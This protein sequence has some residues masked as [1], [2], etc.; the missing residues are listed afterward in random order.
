MKPFLP[1]LLPISSSEDAFENFEPLATDATIAVATLSGMMKTSTKADLFWLNWLMREAQISNVLEGT[2]TTLDEVLGENAG[3]RVPRERKDD[4]IEVLNYRDAM[5]FGMEYIK[6]RKL[7]TLSFIKQLHSLLLRGARGENK[8]PGNF[9]TIQVHIGNPVIYTPPEAIHLSGLLDN[10]IAFI[11]RKDINPLVQTAI[12]HAQFEMIHPFCD[13]NGRIGRLLI[14]IFLAYRKVLEYPCFYMSAYLHKNRTAYYSSLN[15]ISSKNNWETWIKFFLKSVI[16]RCNENINLLN[17]MTKLY[18]KSKINFLDITGSA[19]AIEVLDYV[20]KKPAFTL[21]D[22]VKN[23]GV[24]IKTPAITMLLNKLE[25]AGVIAKV[26]EKI[27]RKPALWRFTELMN[28][29]ER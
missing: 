16:T 21:P 8:T 28:L 5:I 1:R 4:V 17:D 27:G 2:V 7:L 13:G 14:S 9:R 20:F 19:H 10:L 23:S 24:A 22:I 25:S 15:Y 6:D 29:I 18:E 3:L 26:S 11:E 12:I